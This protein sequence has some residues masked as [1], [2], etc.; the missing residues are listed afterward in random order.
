MYTLYVASRRCFN[1]G[2]GSAPENAWSFVVSGSFTGT[3]A[4]TKQYGCFILLTTAA[5][6]ATDC[7]EALF[8]DAACRALSG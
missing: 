6:A 1:G 8:V 2:L 4:K 3:M 5:D 7:H